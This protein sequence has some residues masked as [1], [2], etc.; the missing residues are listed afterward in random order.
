[1]MRRRIGKAPGVESTAR[2]SRPVAAV[3]AIAALVVV[4]AA[5]FAVARPGEAPPAAAD[6]LQAK[7]LGELRV[8]TGWLDRFGAEGYIGEVGWP[9]DARGDGSEW[10]RLASMWYDEADGARLW[11]TAWATGSLFGSTYR[12]NLYDH[13]G[14]GL[15]PST[16]AVVVERAAPRGVHRGV[17][18]AGGEFGTQA[19]SF[20]N[21]FPGTYGA[22]YR[23]DPPET[24]SYLA[25]RGHRLVRLP[26]RWERIQ[27][28]LGAPLD[29]LELGRL[30]SAVAGARAAGLSVVL[31]LHNFGAYRTPGGPLRLGAEI[32]AETFAD[33][34]RLLAE[35]MKDTPGIVGYGLMNEPTH[36]QAGQA[37]TPERAWE[38]ASQAAVTAIRSTGERRLVMVGGYPWSSVHDWPSHHPRPWITDPRRNLRYEAHHYWDRDHSGT[39]PA[40]YDDELAAAER[41]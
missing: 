8:F 37:G 10:N 32:S 25:R 12:L 15:V 27:P 35:A 31:D 21:E 40:T 28:Q 39:Y 16:Q 19:P 14:R 36:V 34:W 22:D 20:S 11:V 18:V 30:R 2:A 6:A 13:D 26:F 9:D 17:A 4:V 41:R 23:F 38:L 24:F 1:M 33:T 5:T 7:A 3:L 29:P